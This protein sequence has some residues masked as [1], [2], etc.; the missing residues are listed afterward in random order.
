VR[1]PLPADP[2][3]P[4]SSQRFAELGCGERK[5]AGGAGK[6]AVCLGP[7]RAIAVQLADRGL[8]RE[9]QLGVGLNL[10]ATRFTSVSACCSASAAT[11]WR[12]AATAS[13]RH[14]RERDTL[15]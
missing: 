14:S 4:C 15:S 13:S 6:E 3:H 2:F 8:D 7:P 11:G 5:V 12:L 1:R 9:R 10:P